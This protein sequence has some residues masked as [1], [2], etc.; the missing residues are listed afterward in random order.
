MLS[1][2]KVKIGSLQAHAINNKS[3]GGTMLPEIKVKR[4]LTTLTVDTSV[5]EDLN[6]QQDSDDSENQRQSNSINS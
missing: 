1:P 4:R 3:N 5:S 2:S 6:F